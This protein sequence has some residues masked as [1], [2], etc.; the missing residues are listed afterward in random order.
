MHECLLASL[1]VKLFLQASAIAY[2]LNGENLVW[3][4]KISKSWPSWP[5]AAI[6]QHEH[7]EDVQ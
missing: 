1:G 2:K 4:P 6:H 5:F 7:D 3:G